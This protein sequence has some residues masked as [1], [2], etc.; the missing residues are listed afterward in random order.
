MQ[1]KLPVI[2]MLVITALLSSCVPKKQD[3]DLMICNAHIYTVDSAFS[4]KDCMIINAGLFIDVGTKSEM[5]RKYHPKETIDLEG[6][7]V[8]PGFIDAHCHFYG[9]AISNL[10]ADLVGTVSF[11]D[12]LSRLKDF[13]LK[14]TLLWIK[15]RGWDQNDWEV[16]EFP[17]NKL[18]DSLYP[19]NPVF[20]IRVDGH[21]ALANSMA[22]QKAGI[23]ANTKIEGGYVEVKDGVPTGIILD[24]AV[25]LVK[26]VIPEYSDEIKS[27]ALIEAAKD[28][29]SVGLTGVGDAGLDKNVIH[30][31]D[32]MQKKHSLKMKVYA[33]LN[34]T[35]EN[36]K[37]FM[38]FGRYKTPY[39]NIRSVKLYADGALGSR[40]AC[41]LEPYSDKPDTYGFLV[42]SRDTISKICEDALKYGYQVNIH[43][44]GDSAV[45]NILNI[46][47]AYLK[48][49]NDLRWRI[50]HSQVVDPM[51]FK[52]F[53]DNNIIPCVNMVHATSDMYW[54]KDRLGEYRIK[55][56]YAYRKLMETNGWI[57]NGSDFPVE[58]INPI[59][60]FYASV[61]RKDVDGFPAGGFQMENS[62]TR[63]EALKAMTIWAAKSFFEERERGS[64]EA[65]K[66]ADFVVTDKDILSVPESEIVKIQVRMT[67]I[68]GEK[69]Y[70]LND[71]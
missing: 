71:K 19:E 33:M 51:D 15:G 50:E 24:N 7:Y 21:A 56:A 20:L 61:C 13:Q 22:L 55:N 70:D 65:G 45:R 9:Y 57:C 63:I 42:S 6:S 4:V 38:Y 31:M 54:A 60:G 28:C 35:M 2:F 39:L 66:Y 67:Y 41:L 16:K 17:D 53:K 43:A 27:K 14:D 36:F 49:E 10:E 58:S 59:N 40:G 46:Y 52:L 62:L 11:D 3:V 8:Y 5:E 26:S 30:L 29:F 47:A 48:G 12:V 25:E 32:S 64:I 34:P 37:T 44:I 68:N 23:T 18:L 69:V 1:N